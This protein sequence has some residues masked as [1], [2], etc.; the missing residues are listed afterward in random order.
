M[1]KR[2]IKQKLAYALRAFYRKKIVYTTK[3]KPGI[4]DR[5]FEYR[6]CRYI[7]IAFDNRRLYEDRI[8]TVD[9][10]I[11]QVKGIKALYSPA[12]VW[13]WSLL[14]VKADNKN[15]PIKKLKK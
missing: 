15:R 1:A 9:V 13:L 10:P 4:M 3:Y 7:R 5:A 8:P 11:S 12:E 14:G 6:G 2:T